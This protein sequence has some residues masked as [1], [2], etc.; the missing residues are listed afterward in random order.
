MLESGS[1]PAHAEVEMESRHSW[2]KEVTKEATQKTG[3][4]SLRLGL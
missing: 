4:E 2:L 1:V 3:K